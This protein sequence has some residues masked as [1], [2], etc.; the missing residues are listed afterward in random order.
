ML[1]SFAEDGHVL[2]AIQAGAR[3]Y[4]AKTIE[5]ESLLES[6]RA[7]VRG[8]L[9]FDAPSGADLSSGRQLGLT[10]RELDVLALIAS[11]LG[12]SEIAAKLCLAQKTVER[13]VATAVVKME[14]RNRSHAVAR[15]VAM[16]LVEVP[17]G[18]EGQASRRAR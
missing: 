4:V 7:V 15:A 12:N 2:G 17:V 3:G 11:G 6:I 9:V 14:A 10:A 18:R 1:S 5:G 13:I 16:R 8:A